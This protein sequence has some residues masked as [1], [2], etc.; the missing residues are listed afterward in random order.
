MAASVGKGILKGAAIVSAFAVV[1]KA[2]GFI[3]KPVMAH[4]FGL[5]WEADVYTLCFSSVI[6]TIGLIPQQLLAPFLPL[7][8]EKRK[9]EGDD[10]AWRLAGSVGT[11]L[12]G[13]LLVVV[14][15]GILAAPQIIGVVSSFKT[16]A[17][18]RLAESLVR[19]MMPA[20]FFMGLFSLLALIQN[21]HKRFA[22]PAM[23]DTVNKL[24]LIVCLVVLHRF[25]GIRGLAAGVVAGAAVGFLIQMFGFGSRV[26]AFR[27]GVDWRDPALR[28]LGFLMLPILFSVVIALARTI[29]DY[30]FASGMAEGST[31]SINYARAMV[32]TLIQLV[33]TAVGVA[34]YPVFSD[35]AAASDR[36]AVSDTLMRSLRLMAL[37]FIPLTVMLILLSVPIVQL[38][39]QH[40]KFTADSVAMTVAPMTY[41]ALGLTAFAVEIMLMRFYFAIKNTLTPAIVGALCMLLHLGVILLFKDSLHNSSMA[42]AATVS[43]T[44]KVA[45]LFML[46][47]SWLPSL[48]GRRNGYFLLKTLAATALMGGVT[49]VVLRGVSSV[50]PDPAGVGKMMGLLMLGARIGVSGL[51]GLAVF[52]AVGFALKV[53]DLSQ[54]RLLARGWGRRQ[55]RP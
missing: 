50:L 20:V 30:R 36:N 14:A 15:T 37:I 44:V 11:L 55:V 1:G 27:L 42:L 33:P 3:Q 35:M 4:F 29:I 10:A 9:K 32:D 51:A 48:Q 26:R 52:L 19:V 39:F 28:Q 13:A 16:P 18:T 46:L 38:T 2:M 40:G 7:F 43:K 34:I 49:W 12:M 41:Y 5:G 22:L 45:V 24:V 53:E 31:A 8:A 23:G 54:I 25:I 21:A 17:A 47:G 6:F